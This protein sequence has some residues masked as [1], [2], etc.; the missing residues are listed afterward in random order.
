MLDMA[1]D[2]FSSHGCNDYELAATE[3]NV[4][5]VESM[6]AASDYPED[7][8][9]FSSDKKHIFTMD[10]MLIR[11]CMKLVQQEIDRQQA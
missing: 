4:E 7:E 6:I 5:L 9:N 11:Y 8:V 1:A 10:W 2:E 3:D